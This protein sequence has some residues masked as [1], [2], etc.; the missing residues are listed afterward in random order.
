[1]D[2]LVA[3]VRQAVADNNPYAALTLALTLPDVCGSLQAPDDGSRKRYVAW[4]DQYLLPTYTLRI[5][6]AQ[7]THVFL[8]GDDCY[9]LRCAVLHQGSDDITEQ[10]A[11]Q[12]ISRF[13][14]VEP[15]INDTIYHRN[16]IDDVLNLDVYFFC[17]ELCQG[18]EAWLQAVQ[19]H[20]VVMTRVAALMR[21]EQ[22]DPDFHL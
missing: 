2:H 22:V 21:I 3:A 6:P 16:T 4:W 1:M 12:V 9:A 5:G 19:A 20:P 17:E 8:N 13:R 11:R 10:R 14:F 15:G 7:T 18:V